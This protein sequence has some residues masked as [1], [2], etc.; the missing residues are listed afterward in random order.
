MIEVKARKGWLVRMIAAGIAFL[1]FA[2]WC[3][4]DGMVRYP[5]LEND[6]QTFYE[7]LTPQE[8]KTLAV[9]M[10]SANSKNLITKTVNGIEYGLEVSREEGSP[11]LVFA[12]LD[13][14]KDYT[15][16]SQEAGG[17]T[18]ALYVKS[19]WDIRTQFIMFAI[20]IIVGGG[21][22]FRVI[23]SGFKSLTADEAGIHT[24][25]RTIPYDSLVEIDKRKWHR[26]SIATVAYNTAEKRGKLK[27][28]DWIFDNGKELLAMIEEHAG[29]DVTTLDPKEVNAEATEDDNN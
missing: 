28:D 15:V 13:A 5:A 27:I 17:N 24:G 6:F 3:L 7:R 14:D 11:Q 25:R 21:I 20:C 10:E 29:S 18:D 26:K 1:G 16:H 8:H 2:G 23:K 9:Q 19:E 4:Y 12:N 22:I